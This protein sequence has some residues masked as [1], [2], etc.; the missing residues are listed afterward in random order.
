LFADEPELSGFARELDQKSGGLI[1]NIIADR[2]FEG[3]P[4]QTVVVYTRGLLPA[5]RIALVGLGKRKELNLDK[6]RSA[7]AS[8]VKYLRDMNIQEA[9][10]SVSAEWLPEKGVRLSGLWPKEFFWDFTGTR[11][12]RPWI[13]KIS[14]R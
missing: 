14:K 1:R 4:S 7:Y 10:T 3:K 13:A 11:P 6:L 12:T 2:D 8:V 5:A 9:A